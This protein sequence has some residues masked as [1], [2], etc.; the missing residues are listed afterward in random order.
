MDIDL[1]RSWMV[2][3][4]LSDIKAGK[5]AGCRT[6]LLGRMK[7]ELCHL[8]DEEDARPDAITPDLGKA[9]QIILREGG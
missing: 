7:C 6:I 1:S 2:G 3:D 4:G 8:M 9:A 5:A